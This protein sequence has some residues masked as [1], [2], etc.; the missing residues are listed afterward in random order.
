MNPAENDRE[1]KAAREDAERSARESRKEKT[2]DFLRGLDA[3]A[4]ALRKLGERST[5]IEKIRKRDL[6]TSDVDLLRKA[7]VELMAFY[8]VMSKTLDPGLGFLRWKFAVLDDVIQ[9]GG[10]HE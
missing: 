6:T 9:R 10:R 5:I 4:E 8:A 1:I 2:I 7:N 3:E